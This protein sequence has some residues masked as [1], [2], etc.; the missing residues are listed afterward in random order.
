M[1]IILGSASPRRHKLLKDYGFDFEVMTSQIDEKAIRSENL[2]DLPLLVAR[3]KLDALKDKIKEPR[4]VITCD[5][6]VLH[7]GK[8]YEK[9]KGE[10]EA[11]SMLESYGTKPAEVICG[12]VLTN[13]ENGRSAE[14]IDSAKV[15]F[16]K[17]PSQLIDEMIQHGKIFDFAG[18]FHPDD[19]PIKPYI[20]HIEG[21]TGTV[22]GL[23]KLLLKKLMHEV[24]V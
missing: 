5:T 10:I 7:D 11:R 15:Y 21:E 13:T 18:A 19:P 12:L 24:T 8:L 17:I 14:G 16:H 23:P 2:R 22:M 3:A 4:L 20:V 6:I 9:P 1:K